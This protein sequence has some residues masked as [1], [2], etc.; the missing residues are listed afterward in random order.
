MIN[1]DANNI[2]IINFFIAG[3]IC[4]YVQ[5]R[6]RLAVHVCMSIFLAA[7]SDWT[8]QQESVTLRCILWCGI[9]LLIFWRRYLK[10]QIICLQHQK[11]SSRMVSKYTVV[12]SWSCHVMLGFA[13]TLVLAVVDS[14]LW[15][16]YRFN[17]MDNYHT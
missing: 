10:K 5:C 1:F 6:S 3:I 14:S 13:S 11:A 9:L 16:P 15:S 17:I 4:E 12:R 2:D 7:R 8:L